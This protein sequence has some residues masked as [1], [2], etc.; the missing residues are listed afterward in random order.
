MGHSN[1]A[2]YPSM[3]LTTVFTS[4]DI[5]LRLDFGI[6]PAAGKISLGYTCCAW[7][8]GTESQFV[9]KREFIRELHNTSLKFNI[10]VKIL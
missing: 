6:N 2:V 5:S 4:F 3:L 10:R 8:G 7:A 1:L 9:V